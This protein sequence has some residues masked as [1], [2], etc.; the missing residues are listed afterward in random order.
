MLRL[1]VAYVY[2]EDSLD[3][4]SDSWH[5]HPCSRSNIHGYSIHGPV[6]NSVVGIIRHGNVHNG[7]RTVNF[8][9]CLRNQTAS[10]TRRVTST[11]S[12]SAIIV[13][14]KN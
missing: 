5:D 6:I 13:K 12:P 3:E 10:E 8:C 1:G 2:S 9:V 7:I 11:A 4:G 14:N